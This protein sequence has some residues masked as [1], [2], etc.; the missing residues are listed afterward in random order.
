M[1]V[2]VRAFA[3]QHGFDG[4]GVLDHIAV[5]H[6]GQQQL[7]AHAQLLQQLAAAGALGGEV[8]EV[9]HEQILKKNRLREPL[10]ESSGKCALRIGMGR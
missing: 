6:V 10:H 5:M 4:L 2:V 9:G 8:D 7:M 1:H 3:G